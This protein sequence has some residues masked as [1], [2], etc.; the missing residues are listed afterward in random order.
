MASFQING[1][2]VIGFEDWTNQLK[3]YND[4]VFHIEADPVDAITDNIPEVK[5]EPPVTGTATV[6]YEGLL[7]FEDLWPRQGDLL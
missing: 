3:D 2:V 5:P 7:A 6:D 1:F 4:L